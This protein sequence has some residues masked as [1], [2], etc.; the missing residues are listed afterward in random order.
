V[1]TGILYLI[2][3]SLGGPV[4]PLLP[5]A[6]VEIVRRVNY[7]VVEN[8]KSARAFLKGVQHPEPLQ[9]IDIRTLDEHTPS[10]DVSGLLQP[11]ASGRDCALVSEAGC[12]AVADPGAA[13]VRLAHQADIRV[14]PLVGPS[15]LLLALMSSGMNGQRFAFHGYLPIERQARAR[16][17][18]DLERDSERVDTTQIFI[19]TPYRNEA[20]FDAIVASCRKDTLLCVAADLTLSSEY[21]RTRPL[22]AWNGDRPQI[23]RRPAVFLLYREPTALRRRS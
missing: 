11:I 22:S 8:P 23:G 9:Q 19:E 7:F 16:T 15:A 10:Q 18:A 1:P 5:A 6:T 14:S 3:T 21:I 4:G 20:L 17:L 2:P 12:P 13:L